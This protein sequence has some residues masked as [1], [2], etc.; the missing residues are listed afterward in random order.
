MV[1]NKRRAA[2]ERDA[3]VERLREFLRLNYM[4]GAEVA[5]QLGVRD[6]TVYSWLQG[7]FRPANPK[8]ISAFLDSMPI[9]SSS[10]ITQPVTNIGST[11]IGVAFQ[12]HAV[13]R[14]V[15]KQRVRF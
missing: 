5:R 6:S 11:K 12:N 1:R 4:T 7:E 13:A 10:G 9:E 8:L 3:L 2:D 14:F 15:R